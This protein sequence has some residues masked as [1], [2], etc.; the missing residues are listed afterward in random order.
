MAQV[1]QDKNFLKI[2]NNRYDINKIAVIEVGRQ[3]Q[4]DVGMFRL[5]VFQP[6]GTFEDIDNTHNW[7]IEVVMELFNLVKQVLKQ[8]EEFISFEKTKI[9]N[10]SL[11]KDI[12]F[13]EMMDKSYTKIC[14][15]RMSFKCGKNYPEAYNKLLIK[16]N[17]YISNAT[18]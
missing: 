18:I 16:Y 12:Q 8:N 7:D 1:K 11:V 14:F 9:V 4:D 13:C 6:N 2:Y 15:D 17:N 3:Y 10:L 5:R